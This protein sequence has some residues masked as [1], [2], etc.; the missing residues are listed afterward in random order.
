MIDLLL[1]PSAER[2][3]KANS[4]IPVYQLLVSGCNAI[5]TLCSLMKNERG[6]FG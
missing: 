4:S 2:F 5:C 3:L 1:A 6:V